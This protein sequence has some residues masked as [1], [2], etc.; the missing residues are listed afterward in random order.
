MIERFPDERSALP[1][2]VLSTIILPDEAEHRGGFSDAAGRQAVRLAGRQMGGP[3]AHPAEGAVGQ[4]AGQGMVDGGVGLAQDECQ[5]RRID[6][7]RL[8]EGVN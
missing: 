6:E 1:E 2:R 4:E 7:R 3:V 5:V 8:P